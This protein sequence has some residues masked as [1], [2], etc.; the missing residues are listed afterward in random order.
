MGGDEVRI[1]S[2]PGR[3]LQTRKARPNGFGKERRA[4]FLQHFAA[5][6]NASAAARE[7]G[8]GVT[9]VYCTR[10]RDPEFAAAWNAALQQGYGTLEAALVARA[11]RA[12]QEVPSP[13]E[14]DH[15]AGE[16]TDRQLGI[17]L[18][19]THR[20]SLGKAPGDIRP[21]RSDIAAV[22]ERLERKM[23]ALGLVEEISST[24]ETGLM[25]ETGDEPDREVGAERG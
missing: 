21:Q 4:R 6:C 10:Q 16:A 18:L 13:T 19:K 1:G 2:G 14:A 17:Q 25:E 15:R 3:R 11:L 20:Q 24:E 5:T 7:A 9:T 23:R 8:V 12:A 22:R